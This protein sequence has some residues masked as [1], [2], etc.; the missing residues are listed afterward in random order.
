MPGEPGRGGRSTT[1]K[2]AGKFRK[3]RRPSAPPLQL[4]LEL[5]ALVNVWPR[6]LTVYFHTNCLLEGAS[7]PILA[8]LGFCHCDDYPR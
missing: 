7:S 2:E 3:P 8:C 1:V 6:V 4:C 5:C